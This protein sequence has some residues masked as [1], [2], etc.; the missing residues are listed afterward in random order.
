MPM[1][2]LMKKEISHHYFIPI[3]DADTSL[4]PPPIQ[5]DRRDVQ[6]PALDT[7]VLFGSNW[8]PFN[9]T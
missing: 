1:A 3:L 6:W 4:L 5:V 2:V 9:Q 7:S 8:T